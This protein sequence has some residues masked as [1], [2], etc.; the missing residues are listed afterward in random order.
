MPEPSRGTK[1]PGLERYLRAAVYFAAGA[2]AFVLIVFGVFM[3]FN[4]VALLAALLL[5]PV[6]LAVLGVIIFSVIYSEDLDYDTASEEG[7]ANELHD[8]ALR[9]REHRISA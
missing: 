4:L 5:L 9:H 1:V 7:F 8:S 2:V 3:Q 6:G